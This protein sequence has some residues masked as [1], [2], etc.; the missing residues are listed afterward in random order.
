[1]HWKAPVLG[2][3]A[4]LCLE[5]GKLIGLLVGFCSHAGEFRL[6]ST[7]VS[8][9]CH[10]APCSLQGQA[11]LQARLDSRQL[12]DSGFAAGALCCSRLLQGLRQLQHL[13]AAGGLQLQQACPPLPVLQLALRH[14]Q[15]VLRLQR[16]AL[17]LVSSLQGTRGSVSAR[18]AEP[19]RKSSSSTFSLALA[20]RP[21]S[22]VPRCLCSRAFLCSSS[23]PSCWMPANLV[24]DVRSVH[25]R[26][27]GLSWTSAGAPSVITSA[28]LSP[29]A[30]GGSAMLLVTPT[31]S[32]EQACSSG[33]LRVCLPEEG[34]QARM[35]LSSLLA[36]LEDCKRHMTARSEE[37]D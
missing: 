6:L 25:S 31:K 36:N 16:L 1:M 33:Q 24:R 17:E 13:L 28:M 10:P 21:T 27:A 2:L 12:G 20:V 11:C 37:Q 5:A 4:E 3:L 26:A 22:K 35:L 29:G 30:T 15:T 19:C 32:A 18:T 7:V 34:S 23:R 9:L 8:A 14:T